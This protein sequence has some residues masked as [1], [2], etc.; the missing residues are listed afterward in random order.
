MCVWWGDKCSSYYRFVFA[1]K[2]RD[3]MR[4]IV[5]SS[6]YHI[7]VNSVTLFVNRRTFL[8]SVCATVCVCAR[9]CVLAS[10][11]V[12]SLCILMYSYERVVHVRMLVVVSNVPR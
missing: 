4:L 11:C 5:S 2:E 3:L 12:D 1:A 10:M 8:L 9:A 6:I 7:A